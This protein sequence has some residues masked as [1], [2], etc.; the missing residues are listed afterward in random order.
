MY[1]WHFDSTAG[2]HNDSKEQYNTGALGIRL[3]TYKKSGTL[4]A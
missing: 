1:Q 2:Q 3:I 4:E